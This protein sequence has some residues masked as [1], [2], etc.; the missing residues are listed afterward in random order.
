MS[1]N[2]NTNDTRRRPRAG[3]WSLALRVLL[4]VSAWQGPLPWWHS[5]GGIAG[6]SEQDSIW[7]VEHLQCWHPGLEAA[8][9]DSLGWHMHWGYPSSTGST[10][11]PTP[12][13]Q[14]RVLGTNHFDAHLLSPQR[15]CST[16]TT[17]VLPLNNRGDLAIVR[18]QGQPRRARHFFDG[19]APTLPLPLRFCIARC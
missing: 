12:R 7:L 2:R 13:T 14:D 19:F 15:S 16:W 10:G 5:H 17:S 6:A 3:R 8:S 18:L 11:Q 9:A 4:L 1:T